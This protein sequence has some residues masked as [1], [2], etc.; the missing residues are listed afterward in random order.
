MVRLGWPPHL[1]IESKG[2]GILNDPPGI[3]RNPVTAAP[4]PMHA[5]TILVTMVHS[6]GIQADFPYP[7]IVDPLEGKCF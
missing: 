1:G 2:F 6:S 7:L 4:G 5:K 3:G